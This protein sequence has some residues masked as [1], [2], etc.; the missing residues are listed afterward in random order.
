VHRQRGHVERRLAALARSSLIV[1]TAQSMIVSVR[2]PRKSNLTR[3][4]GFDVVL[5]ELRDDTRAILVAIE[6]RE[7][8]STD[9]AITTPTRVH[10][11]IAH[12]SL[13]RARHV[14]NFAHVLL[15][16]IALAQLLFFFECVI[17]R[18]AELERDQLGDAVAKP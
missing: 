18:D 14:E 12:E 9:G 2:S 15:V 16:A 3:T 17:K 10:A 11:G 4:R 1:R 7:V 5:V 13:E 8:V 6:R